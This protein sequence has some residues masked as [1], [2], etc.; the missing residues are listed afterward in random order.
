MELL[1]AFV[2]GLFALLG[3]F[4]GAWLARRTQYEK[5]LL[6]NRSEVFARFLDLIH[7][8]QHEAIESLSNP[9]SEDIVREIGVTEAYLPASAY[10]RVVRLY[11]P[12]RYREEFQLLSRKIWAL[13]ASESLGGSRFKS[14]SENIDRIQAIFEECVDAANG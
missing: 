3:A 6:E 5:W 2:V 8:G 1:D 13:H 10:A 14:M 12:Y 4:A 9:K 11:L 7:Q